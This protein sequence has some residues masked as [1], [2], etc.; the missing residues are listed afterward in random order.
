M[1]TIVVFGVGAVGGV[2]A[3]RLHIAG[4]DV[5]AVARGDH[6]H[7]I[8]ANGLGI[9]GHA[10][11]ETVPLAVV[12]GAAE[13]DWST[14]PAVVL[15]VKSHQT[16]AA[17]DD[18]AAW[19]PAETPVFVAQNGVANEA[20]VLRRFANVYG[21]AVLLP[22]AHLEPGVVVQ[23]SHPIAGILDLGRYPSGR[24]DTAEAL[25]GALRTAGFLSEV[26]PDIM[27]WKYRKLIANLG[28]GVTAAFRP[29]PAAD[30]LV[31]RARAEATRILTSA[32]IEF[33]SSERDAERRG[34]AVTGRL[35][36]DLFGSTWQSVARGHADVET[37]WFNGEIVLRARLLG[38]VAPVNE[39]IQRVTAEHAREG[40]PPRSLDAGD[41]LARLGPGVT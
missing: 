23:Q 12:A 11:T 25:S 10:G 39:L 13:V 14:R 35:R 30:E 16:A 33:V 7:A 2:I 31:G 17:L 36:D 27:A 34:D 20:S 1:S 9:V 15:A 18:L 8:R 3:G 37:D 22:A 40:R 41:A 29:G 32:G 38:E 26:R 6:L 24:D 21:V 19:A 4:S 28:N 5:T